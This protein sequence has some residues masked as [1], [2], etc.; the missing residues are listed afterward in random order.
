MIRLHNTLTRNIDVFTPIK[1]GE[2][3]LYTCGPTVYNHAHIGNLSSY[4]FADTLRRTLS[5]KHSNVHH[6]MNLTDIDDKTVRDSAIKHP[7]LEPMEALHKLTRYYEAVFFEDME[8]IG[9]DIT[10][11]DFV[12]ATDS[13]ELMQ[14]LITKLYHDNLAYTTDD[15]VY[16]SLSEYEKTRTYGQLSHIINSAQA[17]HRINNDEYDKENAQDFALWKKRKDGEP[18][19]AFTLG[20]EQLDGR[21]GWHIECSAMSTSRLGQPFDIHTGGI[22]LIFPHHEN[23]IAQSTGGNQPEMY[24]QMFCHN[25]HM[26][27]DGVKMAKSAG[28]FYTLLDIINK[29]YDPLAFR[30]MALQSHYR[31][32]TNFSWEN[33]DAATNR[34]KHWRDTACLRWQAYDTLDD[35]DTYHNDEHRVELLGAIQSIKDTMSDDLNTPETLQIVDDIFSRIEK[36]GPAD[37]HQD[38]SQTLLQTIDDL[39][40]LQLLESTP[41]IDD[42]A[43]QLIL[44]RQRAREAKDWEASDRLRDQ[45]AEKN[46]HVKDTA[47]QPVWT[48]LK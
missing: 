37:V 7:G 41:D 32:Q 3:K 27:V 43:K 5:S 8:A 17:E 1:E 28:N 24:A 45:L 13:I 11:F 46:I 38:V 29:G 20:G 2:V 35:G 12:R 25:E 6:V 36:S 19:W 16:F 42:E 44:E 48:Y 47:E 34:L 4:V 14:Q 21:P 15:G 9:V 39:L 18:F 23:E 33:L 40:G 22:D 31:N 10:K 26:L 30:M